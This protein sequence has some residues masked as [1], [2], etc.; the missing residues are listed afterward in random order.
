MRGVRSKFLQEEWDN[1]EKEK[2]KSQNAGNA[3]CRK[4]GTEV[5]RKERNDSEEEGSG[6]E[7][8]P[9][10]KSRSRNGGDHCWQG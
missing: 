6:N 1:Q 2:K 9:I 8:R 3:D 4:A 7:A 10:G 5:D